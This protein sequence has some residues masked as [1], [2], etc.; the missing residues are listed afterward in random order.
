MP[1]INKN[2]PKKVGDKKFG[3]KRKIGKDDNASAYLLVLI[4][5]LIL[6]VFALFTISNNMQKSENAGS[7]MEEF[8]KGKEEI[9][10]E[11]DNY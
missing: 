11:I 10:K 4:V 6:I 7:L 5:S 3:M 8:E 2:S 1:K 9:G